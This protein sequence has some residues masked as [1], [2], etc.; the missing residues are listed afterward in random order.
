M[1]H[2]HTTPISAI[3]MEKAGFAHNDFYGAQ[4]YGR[5]CYHTFEGIKV[6]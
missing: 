1:I 6:R 3:I 2:T 4:L 5:I